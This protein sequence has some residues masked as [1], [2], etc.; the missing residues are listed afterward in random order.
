MEQLQS[1]VVG[2]TI[3]KKADGT[4]TLNDIGIAQAR[5]T[6]LAAERKYLQ[7]VAQEG[8][9]KAK[10]DIQAQATSTQAAIDGVNKR[11]ASYQSEISALQATVDAEESTFGNKIAKF[12]GV[13]LNAD[14]EKQLAKLKSGLQGAKWELN[15]YKVAQ[16][17]INAVIASEKQGDIDWDKYSEQV[18]SALNAATQAAKNNANAQNQDS[19]ARQD[20]TDAANQNTDAQKKNT[21]TLEDNTKTMDK[22]KE[23]AK[24]Y[25]L[26]LSSL[27]NTIKKQENVVSNYAI[28]SPERRKAMEDE[29]SLI[30]QEISTYKDAQVNA[31]SV[32][33]MNSFVANQSGSAIGKQVVADAEKYLNTPY[34]WGGTS[35]Q[36]FDCSGLV[37]Y[38]YKQV[39][40]QLSRTTYDQY[41][42]GKAVSKQNLE[43]GD[44]VFFKGSDGSWD[45]PGHVGIYAGDEKYIQAPKTGDV[46]KISDLN[47]RSD[48]VGARRVVTSNNTDTTATSSKLTYADIVNNAAKTYGVDANLIAGVIKQE[49]G[50]NAIAK[51][52]AGAMGLMQLMPDTATSLGVKDAYNPYQNVMGGVKYLSTLLKKYNGNQTLA[53]AAYNAGEG[54]VAKYGG[55]PPFSE[56]QN[57]IKKVLGYTSQF[58]NKDIAMPTTSVS[59]TLSD[60]QDM[61]Q[62]IL[63]YDSKIEDDVQKLHELYKNIY[64]D[65]VSQYDNQTKLLDNSI[66]KMNNLVSLDGEND[67]A[68][69]NNLKQILNTTNQKISILKNEQNFVNSQLKNPNNIYTDAVLQEIKEKADELAVT[70]TDVSKAVKEAGNAWAQSKFDNI[71]NSMQTNITLIENA[72]NRLDN[73]TT[74][75][76]SSKLNLQ[77]Q[78]VEEDKKY[79]QDLTDLLRELNVEEAQTNSPYLFD[80]IKE[81]N[82]ELD[83]TKTTL[84]EDQK[85]IEDIKNSIS[86]LTSTI[87]DK[88]K[89]VIQQNNEL[90]KDEL[91]KNLKLFEDAVD[92]EV[93]KLEEAKK[94]LDNNETNFTDIQNINDLQAQL[95]AIQGSDAASKSQR[96]DLQKQL[97]DANRQFASD[98][99]N[100]N[101]QDREDAL[102]KAKEDYEKINQTYSDAIDNSNDDVNLNKQANQALIGGYLLDSNGNKVDLETALKNYEDQFGEGLT[103]LGNKIKTELIDQL[104]EVQDLM[105]TFGTLDT[106]KITGNSKVKTV[107]GTGVDLQ[108]AETILGSEGYSY[109]DTN[110]TPASEVNPQSG[111]VILGGSVPDNKIN[112][113]T[114]LTGRDRYQTALFLQ[115]FKDSSNGTVPTISEYNNQTMS[116]YIKQFGVISQSGRI[117]GSGIDLENAKKLLGKFGYTF[118]DTNDISGINLNSNDIVVGGPG[119]MKG[120]QNILPSGATWLWGND[121]KSTLAAIQNQLNEF[122]RFPVDIKGFADGGDVDFTGMAMVHGTRNKPETMLNYEQGQGLHSFLTQLPNKVDTYLK[123]NVLNLDNSPMVQNYN[124]IMRTIK[125]VMDNNKPSN[126]NNTLS[127][128]NMYNINIDKVIGTDEDS[129]EELA[130]VALNYIN[131]RG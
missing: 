111:D 90:F 65:W 109:I 34:V 9:T 71:T 95:N 29:I 77:S 101:I 72:L 15:N 113:A 124:N 117:F 62:K 106:T 129:A 69:I 120:S 40:I 12:F 49:S 53:L 66:S 47:A 108:N 33:S 130:K 128:P 2:L 119:V 61:M 39:G 81:F 17:G 37:Q 56:T 96:A 11:I 21:K 110:S 60:E 10:A 107:Y 104:K 121:S 73:A 103:V 58:A 57:Y 93:S 36:G 5:M 126:N 82:A 55:V 13:N 97:D 131:K 114:N 84:T 6:S 19:Q 43:A 23:V 51:S 22:A 118:I 89:T 48:Y 20:G 92:K 14:D 7:L 24:E 28:G 46:V 116:D 44:L 68:Y 100:Q 74:V 85:A 102:N 105:N 50:F 18:P 112:G 67:N 123:E 31:S 41:K 54:N 98:T 127:S 94:K 70:V 27:S 99:M 122:N 3:V 52:S 76:L 88:I 125:N 80:K 35:P 1:K 38:V 59:S 75:D 4:E 30:K 79:I 87:L 45:S 83:K 86:D 26:Q 63:D 115:M 16:Q 91:D 8:Q 78:K 64:E 32:T 25:E 42:Q